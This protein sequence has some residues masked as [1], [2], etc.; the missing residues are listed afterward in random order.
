MLS[1]VRFSPISTVKPSRFNSSATWRASLI[2]SFRGV[3][4]SG[5]LALPITSAKRSP[6]AD[7]GAVQATEKISDSS[8]ARLVF[9]TQ[10]SSEKGADSSLRPGDITLRTPHYQTAPAPRQPL[11]TSWLSR[12]L[13]ATRHPSFGG[14]S[15]REFPR[16]ARSG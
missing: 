9:I 12:R 7:E 10:G 3:S 5:Y 1:P 2:G 11:V 8:R 4:A 16:A 15:R 13:R 6:A 14:D